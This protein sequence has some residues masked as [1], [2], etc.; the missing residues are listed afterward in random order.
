MVYYA[1]CAVYIDTC[2]QHALYILRTY[3]NIP[4]GNKILYP[5]RYNLIRTSR[6]PVSTLRSAVLTAIIHG[7]SS[8][9]RKDVRLSFIHHVSLPLSSPPPPSP[10]PP[11]PSLLFS[12]CFSIALHTLPHPTLLDCFIIASLMVHSVCR[13]PRLDPP[14]VLARLIA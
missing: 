12:S 14:L 2:I 9:L 13:L 6:P 1:D 7:R 11:P 4:G 8:P 10:P 5:S 3:P